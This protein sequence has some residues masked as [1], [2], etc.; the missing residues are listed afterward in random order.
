MKT[1]L[2][3]AGAAW[4]RRLNKDRQRAGIPLKQIEPSILKQLIPLNALDDQRLRELSR[5]VRPQYLSSGETVFRQGDEDGDLV[6]LVGGSISMMSSG[7]PGRRLI[8]A[9][10]E[11]AC[12]ALAKLRPRPYTGIVH[13]QACVIRIALTLLDRML[14]ESRDY[15]VV[16]YDGNDPEWMLHVL[17]HPCFRNL[18]S[19]SF[20]A[21]FDRLIPMQVKAGQTIVR[22]GE[23]SQ[24][25]YLIRQGRAGLICEGEN[26]HLQVLGELGETEG[27]GEETLQGNMTCE[28]TVVMLTDGLLMR[29]AVADYTQLMLGARKVASLPAA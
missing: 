9:G 23:R 4:R 29:L 27:F 2:T 15:E 11:E 14:D 7:H 22:Q 1:Y 8:T 26:G 10:S 12:Y 28:T 21:L 24:H 18:P 17:T 13:G 6:Y 20:D 16:E 5:S 19:N 25:Y 3:A